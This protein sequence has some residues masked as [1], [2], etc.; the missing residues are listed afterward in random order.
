MDNEYDLDQM[1]D[2]LTQFKYLPQKQLEYL[3]ETCTAIVAKEPNCVELQA[4]VNVCGSL[5]GRMSSLQELFNVCGHPPEADFLFLGNYCNV[6]KFGV[7]II[8]LLMALKIKHP[9]RVTLLRG[10]F[11]NW[12]LCERKG[13]FEECELKYGNDYPFTLILNFFKHLPL[14]AVI[15]KSIFCTPSGI[16]RWMQVIDEI[17]E[18]DRFEESDYDSPL[19]EFSWNQADERKGWN[20]SHLGTGFCYG[21]DAT[22]TF[23]DDNDFDNAEG[24]GFVIASSKPLSE[25]YQWAHGKKILFI[26]SCPSKFKWESNSSAFACL[27]EYLRLTIHQF[28]PIADYHSFP[29]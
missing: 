10:K 26:Q 16:P 11:D 3:C 24:Q 7:E 23:L 27:D 29:E 17:F 6:G 8:S 19:Q 18:V 15:N 21:E 9:T 12:N 25:G 22:D 4:P 1:I 20:I 28:Q 13:F 2:T 5:L 14:C